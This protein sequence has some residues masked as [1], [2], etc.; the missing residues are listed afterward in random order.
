[1]PAADPR[2]LGRRG[3]V[4]STRTTR[5]DPARTNLR[6]L[7]R[8][9]RLAIAAIMTVGLGL[10]AAVDAHAAAL[11]PTS[12]TNITLSP[13]VP[14]GL[15]DLPAV[16][17]AVEHVGGGF[18]RSA[19]AEPPKG[20]P[21]PHGGE[22]WFVIGPAPAGWAR[23]AVLR[24][25]ALA[26]CFGCARATTGPDGAEADAHP[27]RILGVD[28]SGARSTGDGTQDGALLALPTNSLL[29][30]AVA[31]RE[32]R[33]QTTPTGSA[34]SSH[35]ALFDLA[36]GDGQMATFA[37]FEASSE[38]SWSRIFSRGDSRSNAARMRLLH[39]ALTVI[40]L[41]SEDGSDRV[42]KT[43]LLS[44]NGTE[45]ASSHQM[46]GGIPVRIPGV[47]DLLLLHAGSVGGLPSVS[48]AT[49]SDVLGADDE[50][51]GLVTA[52]AD[53]ATGI[54][55]TAATGSPRDAPSSA[56]V[57]TPAPAIAT[58]A[59]LMPATAAPRIVGTP[60]EGSPPDSH[61]SIRELRAVSGPAV[62][63]YHVVDLTWRLLIALGLFA[64]VSR[65][66]LVHRGCAARNS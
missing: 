12:L 22:R 53:G 8:P 64:L 36:I 9:L 39:G 24:V 21:R 66:V 51:L 55:M 48:V 3:K 44:I 34:A 52:G 28:V 20:R 2:P 14:S 41:H 57:A 59:R 50:A 16:R 13:N 43:Y 27:V 61:P 46:A 60:G 23:A 15:N 32:T 42:G 49:V 45:L 31:H 29:S 25:D 10:A 58:T 26:T 65:R 33:A 11:P 4:K 18:L 5:C 1:M 47:L 17:V 35:A 7:G 54:V 63:G 62:G 37:A 6:I 56:N 40:I 19:A 30:L 38:A